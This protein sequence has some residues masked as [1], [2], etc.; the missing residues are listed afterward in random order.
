M[1]VIGYLIA[2]DRV[3]ALVIVIVKIVRDARLGVGQVGKNRPLTAFKHLCF[4]A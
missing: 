1:S 4:E 2:N 3:P